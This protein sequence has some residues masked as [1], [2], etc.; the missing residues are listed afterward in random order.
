M[1]AISSGGTLK[2]RMVVPVR[3]DA[4]HLGLEPVGDFFGLFRKAAAAAS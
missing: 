4:H 2:S 1:A 3:A